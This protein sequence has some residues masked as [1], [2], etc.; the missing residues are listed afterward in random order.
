MIGAPRSGTHYTAAVLRRA[1]LDIGHEVVRDDGT[2]SSL[3]VADDYY[4]PGQDPGGRRSEFAFDHVFHQTRHP[5]AAIASIAAFMPITWWHWQEK[6]TG[7]SYDLPPLSRAARAWL[8]FNRLAE[9]ADPELRFRVEA[10]PEVWPEVA[11]R[12]SLGE[13]P[14]PE[15]STNLHALQRPKVKVTWEALGVDEEPVRLAAHRYGYGEAS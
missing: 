9:D 10:L 13:T 2:V 8:G 11:S 5:L 1:G 14:C 7:V 4:Y 3:F 6:H 12:L 15:V